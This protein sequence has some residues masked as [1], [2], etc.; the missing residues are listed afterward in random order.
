MNG[1]AKLLLTEDFRGANRFRLSKECRM[2]LLDEI[3]KAIKGFKSFWT[4]KI[5]WSNQHQT[6]VN[7]WAY[8]SLMGSSVTNGRAP[9][10]PISLPLHSPPQIPLKLDIIPVQSP[11]MLLHLTQW[12]T[13]SIEYPTS[14][15]CSLPRQL[16]PWV[17]SSFQSSKHFFNSSLES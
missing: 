6:W 4:C 14:L 12:I 15:I 13:N 3:I 9:N 5:L 2:V 16:M 17:R 1:N 11:D 8:R 7:F 10:D